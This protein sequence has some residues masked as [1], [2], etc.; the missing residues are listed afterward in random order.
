MGANLSSHPHRIISRAVARCTGAP[1]THATCDRGWLSS[2][3]RW[4]AGGES[5]QPARDGRTWLRE[6]R[7][8]A[9]VAR[10]L[11]VRRDVGALRSACIRVGTGRGDGE[12]AV[13][14]NPLARDKGGPAR[15][16][17]CGS[18]G[19]S[20]TGA[21]PRESRCRV[22][23]WRR[24]LREGPHGASSPLKSRKSASPSAARVGA[25][26]RLR[27]SGPMPQLFLPL[28]SPCVRPE[29]GVQDLALDPWPR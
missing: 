20:G 10:G 24:R 12:L 23:V 3:L 2:R 7:G 9:A 14:S 27:A 5:D 1:W 13:S 25:C 22:A 11:C 18:G 6:R 19:G 21:G 15:P 29:A 4:G 17:G 16:P 8:P 28:G 26:C